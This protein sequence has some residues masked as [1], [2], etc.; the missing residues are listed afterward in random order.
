[1]KNFIIL[2]IWSAMVFAPKLVFA[3]ADLD[4]GWTRVPV[5]VETVM[6]VTKKEDTLFAFTQ[7]TLY[8]SLDSGDTWAKVQDLGYASKT[9][10]DAKGEK[11]I[12]REDVYGAEGKQCQ[13]SLIEKSNVVFFDGSIKKKIIDEHYWSYWCVVVNHFYRY[14]VFEGPVILN[15]NQI[16]YTIYDGHCY[17]TYPAALEEQRYFYLDDQWVSYQNLSKVVGKWSDQWVTEDLSGL[18]NFDYVGTSLGVDDTLFAASANG[19][20]HYTFDGG[21]TWSE[22]SIPEGAKDYFMKDGFHVLITTTGTYTS[23]DGLEYDLLP[24]FIL[25]PTG[26]RQFWIFGNFI[27]LKSSTAWYRSF[28][29][30]NTWEAFFPKGIALDKIDDLMTYDDTVYVVGGGQVYK[31]ICNSKFQLA[32]SDKSFLANLVEGYVIA[33][34]N[35]VFSGS[36]KHDANGWSYNNL[37]AVKSYYLDGNRVFAVPYDGDRIYYTDDMGATWKVV[38]VPGTKVTGL[39]V[40][41]DT[42]AV[43]LWWNNSNYIVLS[44]D[45]GQTWEIRFSEYWAPYRM[46]LGDTTTFIWGFGQ[47]YQFAGLFDMQPFRSESFGSHFPEMEQKYW[48]LPHFFVGQWDYQSPGEQPIIDKETDQLYRLVLPTVKEVTFPEAWNTAPSLQEGIATGVAESP[49]DKM[50]FVSSKFNGLWRSNPNPIDTTYW[51]ART[52]HYSTCKESVDIDGITYLSEKK[53]IQ[54]KATTCEPD[55]ILYIDFVSPFDTVVTFQTCPGYVYFRGKAY[56]KGTYQTIWESD[57]GCDTSVTII[58]NNLV[59]TIVDEQVFYGWPGDSIDYNGQI[60]YFPSTHYH[61][62]KSQNNCDSVKIILSFLSKLKNEQ[63]PFVMACANDS[64]FYNNQWVT[65]TGLYLDTIYSSLGFDSVVYEQPIYFIEDQVIYTSSSQFLCAGDSLLVNGV[66]ITQPG[67][68]LVNDS[69]NVCEVVSL[70]V[71][72]VQTI[73]EDVNATAGEEVAGVVVWGDTLFTQVTP[74]L[75][76]G[77][78][79]IVTNYHVSVLVSTNNPLAQKIKLYPN[80]S[81]DWV[82]ISHVGGF[83]RLEVKNV[84]G[85]SMGEYRLKDDSIQIDLHKYASGLYYVILH[86]DSGGRAV[87]TLEII[88]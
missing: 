10:L 2:W 1:M 40:N 54:P 26:P 76:Y 77:C 41:G 68:Y 5:G 87:L 59:E 65:E 38:A 33:P 80:P 86:Q 55:T 9:M 49:S 85:E 24:S 48:E 3:Q 20:M 64:I 14:N 82:K 39:D 4:L 67:V 21:N 28:D 73:N 53:Y 15:N 19:I 50:L 35:I 52:K 71:V 29:K 17:G 31:H 12:Y 69:T 37:G 43:S 34:G 16:A 84:L 44:I 25:Y 83:S 18:N 36:K 42:L 23:L 30:G 70:D 45:L 60:Y 7:Y 22:H 56:K 47:V 66:T 72:G 51:D 75:E 11:A 79:S 62:I 13:D 88:R 32:G 63:L 8:A 6:A 58:V 81:S 57:T 74:S 27:I 78:D 46:Y 61:V